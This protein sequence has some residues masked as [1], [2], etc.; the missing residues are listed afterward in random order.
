ME[1]VNRP[2]KKAEQWRWS[3][4]WNSKYAK[5]DFY[6]IKT[7]WN[8]INK[9]DVVFTESRITDHYGPTDSRSFEFAG[10]IETRFYRRYLMLMKRLF[11]GE[12]RWR[13][14]WRHLRGPT[15]KGGAGLA[16][17]TGQ[18]IRGVHKDPATAAATNLTNIPY[19]TPSQWAVIDQGSA[20]AP[21]HTVGR[22]AEC[23]RGFLVSLTTIWVSERI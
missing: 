16:E 4:F 23:R 1:D 3:I 7:H 13:L 14:S 2:N 12:S 18:S 8:C 19:S 11:E 10:C 21:T 9:L 5:R 17:G 22:A 6:K 15:G 20:R